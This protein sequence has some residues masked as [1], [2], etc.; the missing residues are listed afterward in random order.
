MHEPPVLVEVV[1]GRTVEARHRGSVVAVE[2][3]GRVIAEAGDRAMITSTRSAIKPIQAI[4]LITSGAADRFKLGSRELAIACASHSGEPLHTNSVSY[5]LARI[6]A[7]ETDLKCGPHRP[8]SEETARRLER[9]G[10]P[11]T[12]LH[13]NC[14]GKHS[15]MLATAIHRG[16]D[17]ADYTSPDHPVQLNITLAFRRFAG[18][19]YTPPVAVDGCSAPT[20]AVPLDSLA[21]AFARLVSPWFS[22]G[23]SDRPEPTNDEAEAAKRIVAAMISQPEMIA[24]TKGRIDTD[25]I[26]SARR[27][28]IG[29]IGAEGVYCIG[30]LPGEQFARGLG[31]AIKIEDGGKRALE[32]AVVESLQQLGLLDESERRSLADY[33]RPLITNH[34]G[35]VVGEVRPVFELKRTE[36]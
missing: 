17:T 10:L 27:R 16:L 26:R 24:G 5:L 3:D 23:R 2:P 19:D 15:A 11:F 29:K 20:F 13:N 32:P 7:P 34:R 12:A 33:Q 6:G 9:E 21:L 28:L 22:R 8:Y 18:L 31:I 1:R 36:C 14:S 30:V 35:L 4:P 25:L